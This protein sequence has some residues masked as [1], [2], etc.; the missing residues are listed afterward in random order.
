V[1]VTFQIGVPACVL[2]KPMKFKAIPVFIA[3]CA[4]ALAQTQYNT[5]PSR[6]FGQP[7][8]SPVASG[9]PNLVEGRELYLPQSI[10]F[11][12]SS[13]IV[14]VADTVNNRVLAWQNASAVTKG[15]MADRRV[16][17]QIDRFST[18]AGGPSTA[19]TTGLNSPDAIAVDSSGNLYVADAGNNRILRFPKPFSQ[20]S[21]LITPDLV[22]GQRTFSS[23]NSANEGAGVP[24]A[25]TLAFAS[26]NLYSTTLA[27]DAQGNL[28]VADPLNN[29]V[30]RFPAAALAAAT[31]EPAADFVLGQTTFDTSAV[32]Q[33]ANSRLN[34]NTLVQPS[35]LAFAESGDL[36]VSDGL[37][38]VLYFKAPIATPGQQATRLLGI[39]T[40]TA[41]DPNP[42]ALNGC[43]STPPQPCES[44]LGA[45]VNGGITPPQGVAVLANSVYVA[46][47]G[48]NRV[49]KYDTPDKWTPECVF[50]AGTSSIVCTS[51]TTISPAG[52]QFIGQV[53][54]QSIKPNQG[55]QPGPGTVARPVALSFLNTDLWVADAANNRV[56]VWPQSGGTYPAATKVLG[57]LDFSFNAPN[58]IEG[59]E[60]FLY[61]PATH[62]ASGGVAVDKVSDPPHLYIADTLNNRV[63][64]FRDA[65]KVKPGDGA[66]I[67]IGQPDPYS[68][69]PNY[70]THD[71]SVPTDSTLFNPVGLL[72]DP[73]TGDLLVADSGN[74]RVIRFTRP[75]DQNGSYHA[76]LVLGQAGFSTH[77]VDPSSSTMR[78]PTGLAL[79]TAGHLLVSDAALNRVLL[80]KKPAGGDF[81]LGQR[82]DAVIGQP[83]FFSVSSGTTANRFNTPSGIATDSSDRLYVADSGNNRVAIFSSVVAAGVDPAAR[84]SPAI[85]QPL[86]I[87]VSSTGEVWVTDVSSGRM[88]RFPIFEDWFA[89]NQSISQIQIAKT[90]DP[91]YPSFPV[92]IALDAND[93]PVI[94]ESNNRVSMYFIQAAFSNAASYVTR[95]LTP[96]MLAYLYRRGPTF[97]PPGTALAA[98]APLP[99][100]LGDYQVFVNGLQ[101]PMFQVLPDRATFQ[102]PWNL[103]VSG[104]ADVQ[105]VR[106]STGEVLTDATFPLHSADPAMFTSNAQGFG[107]LAVTNQDGS[108]NT[109]SN[110]AARGSVISLYG[111]GIGPIP[112]APADGQSAGGT[113]PAAGLPRVSMNPGGLLPDANVLYFGLVNWFPGV[114]QLNIKIP[115][116]VPPGAAVA[117]AFSWQD[118]FSNDGPTGRLTTTIAV[119]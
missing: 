44:S 18:K 40:P 70:L 2:H 83:D 75:F 97:A 4:C 38:R 111:T 41:A 113:A 25:K 22:I 105:L 80:F 84:F 8:L 59:R 99:A 11:D 119:K 47:T 108:V 90:L 15:N 34:K 7:R 32:P 116:A 92:A 67:V 89:T 64:G 73:A 101:A 49:V 21:D 103:P 58:L 46:D 1:C 10:A 45:A 61:D 82:A 69:S 106:V 74:G 71:A 48:N 55:V 30:L 77:V 50:T 78:S 13:N 104:D 107:Q 26:G 62:A 35:G 65:R 53:N 56:T 68:S 14:Y 86:A 72:V 95:G 33:T 39:T 117:V 51:G 17:G 91:N 66:D 3:A 42:R 36:Y 27:F 110:P 19:Q 60:L 28:W 87:A 94:A 115:D 100:T 12:K 43:P 102:V 88:L 24:S 118:Y 16:I 98:A 31:V 85:G 81:S 112:T 37:S 29:R 114:F 76:N 109:S 93:N 79:T 57:Q 63:L 6:A 52:L 54:G 20:T 96:G 5:T 23:G 9:N